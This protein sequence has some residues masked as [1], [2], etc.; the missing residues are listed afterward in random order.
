MNFRFL[1]PRKMA[2]DLCFGLDNGKPVASYPGKKTF[3]GAVKNLKI[4]TP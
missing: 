4:T 1:I 2:E 3:Q